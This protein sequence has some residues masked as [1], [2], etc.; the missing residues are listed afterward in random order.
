LVLDFKDANAKQKLEMLLRAFDAIKDQANIATREISQN[1][2][3]ATRDAS[4][5]EEKVLEVA[6]SFGDRMRASAAS[7]GQGFAQ[8]WGS[9]VTES[10][11]AGEALKQFANLLMTTV[12][13]AIIATMQ[14]SAAK[15]VVGAAESLAAVPIVGPGLATTAAIA[16]LGFLK[17]IMGAFMGAEEGGFVTGGIQR[18]DSVPIMLQPGE[19]VMPLDEVKG[20]KKFASQMGAGEGSSFGGRGSQINVSFNSTLPATR[21]QAKEIMKRDILPLIRSLEAGGY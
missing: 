9:M 20:M 21:T 17:G 3:T 15:T 12:I 6:E 8:M 11:T 1:L 18:K 2:T 19:Y 10:K 7:V 5:A 13:D 16:M 4:K 14:A